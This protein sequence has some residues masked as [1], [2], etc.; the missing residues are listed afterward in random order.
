MTSKRNEIITRRL[1]HEVPRTVAYCLFWY[2]VGLSGNVIIIESGYL[3]AHGMFYIAP[4]ARAISL[5]LQEDSRK[6]RSSKNLINNALL[7]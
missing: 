2:H 4:R 7:F 1:N 6:N 5:G 3:H